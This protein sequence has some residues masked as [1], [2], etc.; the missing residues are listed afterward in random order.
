MSPL[1]CEQP[2]GIS[3][4]ECPQ[5]DLT[6]SDMKAKVTPT[7]TMTARS[8]VKNEIDDKIT[9]STGK[10]NNDASADSSDSPS[11]AVTTPF[12]QGKRRGSKF[13]RLSCLAPGRTSNASKSSMNMN[14]SIRSLTDSAPTVL[15]RTSTDDSVSSHSTPPL[16]SIMS[17]R[18]LHESLHRNSVTSTSSRCRGLQRCVSFKDVNIREYERV[19]GDNPSVT[20]GPPLAIG[21]RYD[22]NP[23]QMGVDGF[24]EGK[25]LPRSSSEFLVP[26]AVREKLLKDHAD[27]SRRDMAAAVRQVTHL[28]SQRRKTVVNLGMSK[29]EE[30]V[31]TVKRTV[32]KILKTRPSYG[33]EEMRLWDEAH[34]VAMEKAKKLEE[35]L[36]KGES[37][38]KHDIYRV[39][40]P[41][42]N[43]VPS[44]KNQA[45]AFDSEPS[46]QTDSQDECPVETAP[47]SIKSS[48]KVA[49]S[50]KPQSQTTAIALNEKSIPTTG[51]DLDKSTPRRS[52]YHGKIDEDH[53]ISSLKKD[54]D[55]R[56]SESDLSRQRIIACES[57]VEDVLANLL[58]DS[59][60]S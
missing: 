21:W 39:G 49:Y 44:M 25:G 36:R 51:Q 13:S 14:I 46:S 8:D 37:L 31:E 2:A 19:L 7:G 56:R 16:R 28:K 54:A 57:D 22:P 60:A 30:R 18:T 41:V 3:T 17:S 5:V 4:A 20:S 48:T 59:D 53:E 9:I 27:V 32:K 40:T 47:E 11:T 38:S 43:I 45:M 6:A 55:Y 50:Y 34:K 42:G 10:I 24:E 35:S 29:T 52:S 1:D 15:I 33:A 23:I 58:L 26:K 12:P